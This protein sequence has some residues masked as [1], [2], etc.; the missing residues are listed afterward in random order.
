MSV[1]QRLGISLGDNGYCQ[2]AEKYIG[3]VYWQHMPQ[4][5]GRGAAPGDAAEGRG[6]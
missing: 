1:F 4:P 2:D 3:I 6:V 5:N